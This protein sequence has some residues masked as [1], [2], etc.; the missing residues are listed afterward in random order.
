MWLA[1]RFA[2]WSLDS[3]AR[4][5]TAPMLVIETLAQRQCVIAANSVALEAGVRHRMTLAEARLR[6]ADPEVL[7]RHPAA[8]KAAMA[9][10][11]GWAWGYSSHVHWAIADHNIECARLII[12][13][14]AS[15]RLFGGRQALL[16]RIRRDLNALG[17][18]FSAGVGDSPQAALAFARSRRSRHHRTT[19]ENLPLTSLALAPRTRA[20]LKACGIRRT[21]ELLALPPAALARRFGTELLDYIDRLRGRRPH[22]L[23]L[24]RL[25]C[26][27]RTHHE[28]SSTVESTQGLAFVL[29]RIFQELAVFLRGAD[30]VIQTLR[31]E[32]VHERLPSTTI[33]LRL[34]KPSDQAEH[35]ERIARERLDRIEL[36]APVLEIGL[37]SDRLRAADHHQ[38][39]LWS[40]AGQQTGDAWPAVLDRLRA[41]LGHE[42]VCW[43]AAPADHRPE[44]ASLWVDAP[45]KITR[46]SFETAL[47]PRPFWLLEPPEALAAGTV[48][49]L[50]WISGPERIE[51]GWWD[52]GQRRDYYRA[53]DSHGR[54][55]WVFQDLQAACHGTEHYYLHGLFG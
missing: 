1:L 7:A 53:I 20:I 13:I 34:V 48:A 14:G 5:S 47:P 18:R 3:R 8:E 43:L 12:E 37:T 32:L 25:P 40:Q 38:T 17:Y 44:H 4:H 39:H 28:L 29:H 10:L 42:A 55:V 19:L 24:Y 11:A 52:Q 46:T 26:R 54:L 9:R 22:G 16:G 23:L 33:A 2:H 27:Y 30:S 51:S 35:L 41:R 6:L 21:G 36:A 49:A 50:T 15:L 45:A 31:L